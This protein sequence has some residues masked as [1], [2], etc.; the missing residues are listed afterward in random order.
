[1]LKFPEGNKSQLRGSQRG[2]QG[3]TATYTYFQD[4]H[5]NSNTMTSLPRDL[6]V[7][8]HGDKVLQR[9]MDRQQDAY[10]FPQDRQTSAVSSGHL[11][12]ER[13]PRTE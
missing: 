9:A 4:E 5:S 8:P 11:A 2:T 6:K 3:Y 12:L 10:P 7:T 1:M 13:A